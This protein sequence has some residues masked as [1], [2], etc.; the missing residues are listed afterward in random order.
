MKGRKPVPTALKIARGNPGQRKLPAGEPQPSTAIDLCVPAILADDPSARAVWEATAPRLHRV[1]LLTEVDLDA[2]TLYCATFARWQAAERHLQV[3][4]LTVVVGKRKPPIVSPYFAV[5]MK[6]Q[7]QCR[8]LLIE[9]GLT[10]VS[11]A[12]VHVPKPDSA[13]TQK[14]RFFGPHAL[15]PKA[16]A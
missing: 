16:R 13:D 3:H 8:A 1:G 6:A 2:L 11:R 15:A 10:P 5:A 7:A 12:R 14:D 9:F 4:G